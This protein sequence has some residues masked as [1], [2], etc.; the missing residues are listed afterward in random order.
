MTHHV[1]DRS[2]M[3]LSL[4]GPDIFIHIG[5]RNGIVVIS[6]IQVRDQVRDADAGE[7]NLCLSHDSHGWCYYNNVSLILQSLSVVMH[8]RKCNNT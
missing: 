6:A 3:L 1:L 2:G 4:T 5:L 7:N 8:K